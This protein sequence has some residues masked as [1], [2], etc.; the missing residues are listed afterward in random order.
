MDACHIVLVQLGYLELTKP[1]QVGVSPNW[2][3]FRHVSPSRSPKRIRT[4]QVLGDVRTSAL[5][6]SPAAW[7]T[8]PFA[9][10]AFANVLF[11]NRPGSGHGRN[12]VWATMRHCR[13]VDVANSPIADRSELQA[14]DNT[15]C[16]LLQRQLASAGQ[17]EASFGIGPPQRSDNLEHTARS[18]PTSVAAWIDATPRVSKTPK[19]RRCRRPTRRNAAS[20]KTRHPDTRWLSFG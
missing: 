1:P 10:I 13:Q 5:R 17:L 9:Q 3:Q 8:V 4:G 15:A 11:S 14:V 6:A 16:D 2:K 12:P 7:V 18:S 20:A 19:C